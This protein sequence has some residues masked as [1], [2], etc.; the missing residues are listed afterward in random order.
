M[1]IADDWCLILDLVMSEPRRAAFTML[2]YWTKHV[3]AGN[4]YHGRERIE[5][6]NDLGLHDEILIAERFHKHLTPKEKTI[7]QK[8]LAGHHLD[9]GR[10][11]MRQYGVSMKYIGFV[12]TAF[13]IAPLSSI[14]YLMQL[15]YDFLKS[16]IRAARSKQ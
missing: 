14:S 13:R 8:R 16:K 9:L 7:L 11:N 6:I 5:V 1:K 2:H 10:L 3:H 12:A 4:I 15:S